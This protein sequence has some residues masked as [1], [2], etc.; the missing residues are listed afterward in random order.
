[1]EWTAFSFCRLISEVRLGY[2]MKLQ[3]NWALFSF[4]AGELDGEVLEVRSMESESAR[5]LGLLISLIR[6]VMSEF[7]T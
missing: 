3:W 2:H 7:G 6:L 1:M 5:R 4:F